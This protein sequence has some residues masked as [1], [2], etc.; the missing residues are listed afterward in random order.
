MEMISAYDFMPT[1]L[2]YLG[3]P[4][5]DAENLPG[6][7]F[8]PLLLDQPMK[9]WRNIVIFDEYGPVRMIRTKEWK[10]VHRYP[11]GP[12]ELYDLVNDSDERRNLVDEPSQKKRIEELKA[13]MEAWFARYVDPTR[14]GI[15]DD[16][17]DPP[18]HHGQVRLVRISRKDK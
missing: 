3:L 7:S 14:D 5:P 2:E 6:K 8:L 1:L 16:G 11:K 4:V 18:D 17:T 15:V 10:Y 9:E 12:N 13:E